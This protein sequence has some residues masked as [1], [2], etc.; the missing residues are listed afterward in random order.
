VLRQRD[1]PHGSCQKRKPQKSQNHMRIVDKIVHPLLNYLNR[2]F[3]Y[4]VKERIKEKGEKEEGVTEKQLESI[5]EAMG[6]NEAELEEEEKEMI[7]GVV[8]LADTEVKE[9]M[10]PRPDMVCA[11]ENS[12][13]DQIREI[14][15]KEGHSRIPIY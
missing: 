11:D 9:I 1:E 14:V 2:L 15:R 3:H 5:T 8:E 6:A 13:L 12:T 10:L 7:H 4:S